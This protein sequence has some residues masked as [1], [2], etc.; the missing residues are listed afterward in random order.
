MNLKNLTATER[1]AFDTI[2]S[3]AIGVVRDNAEG[4]EF[5]RVNLY[6]DALEELLEKGETEKEIVAAHFFTSFQ[7]D[8]IDK[9]NQIEIGNF[10]QDEMDWVE[11]DGTWED[12]ERG[13]NWLKNM[14]E[15]MDEEI[16]NAIINQKEV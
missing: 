2:S 12:T 9:E 16:Y 5:V 3:E 14:Q 1:Q 8:D 7:S 10:E 15:R 6:Q 4:V 13:E 11:D